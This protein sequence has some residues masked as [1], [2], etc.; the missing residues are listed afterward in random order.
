M[1]WLVLDKSTVGHMIAV[2]A[3]GEIARYQAFLGTS[4]ILT[5]PVAVLLIYCG[6]G[7]AGVAVAIVAM[8]A[9]C[10]FGRLFFARRLVGMHVKEWFSIVMKPVIMVV[11]ITLL[12]GLLPRMLM[13][14]SF[15]RLC[16]TVICCE[17]AYLPACWHLVL[18][19]GEKKFVM[20][21][22]KKIVGKRGA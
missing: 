5:L 3:N 9:I 12:V 10:T 16:L 14:R 17:A 13:P 1:I 18:D 21:R 7:V 8:G 20:T 19:V 11:I 2:S 4:L 6:L 22:V 15:V